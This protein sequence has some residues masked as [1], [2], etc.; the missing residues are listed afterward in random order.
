MYLFYIPKS[1][2]PNCG[3]CFVYVLLTP[4]IFQK[5]VQHAPALSKDVLTTQ[6]PGTTNSLPDRVPTLPCRTKRHEP[7]GSLQVIPEVSL[8]V[9]AMGTRLNPGTSSYRPT[10]RRVRGTPPWQLYTAFGDGSPLYALRRVC[11]RTTTQ[12]SFSG[13]APWGFTREQPE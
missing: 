3:A 8:T 9:S 13:S 11:V 2:L 6:S 10:Q 1:I 7:K 5:R 4:S 12:L